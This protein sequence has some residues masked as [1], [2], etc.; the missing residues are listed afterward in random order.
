MEKNDAAAKETLRN[1]SLALINYA[2]AHPQIGYPRSLAALT[3]PFEGELVIPDEEDRQSQRSF[4]GLLDESF[5]A[6]P[7][8]KAGYRFRYLQTGTGRGDG[9]NFGSFEITAMPL[10]FGKTGGKS[11]LLDNKGLHVTREN[12]PATE[13]DPQPE[14]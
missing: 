1:L 3:E 11:Y 6:D 10:E 5:A 13:Q 14:D 9:S 7:L 8:I 2:I 4:S 12:R